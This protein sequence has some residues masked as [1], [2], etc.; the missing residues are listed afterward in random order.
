MFCRAALFLFFQFEHKL[1]CMFYREKAFYKS[2][3]TQVWPIY[4]MLEEIL[5]SCIWSVGGGGG[6]VRQSKTEKENPQGTEHH[7]DV[8][9]MPT[10][11][12]YL[13]RGPRFFAVV[14]YWLFSSLY[15]A[16]CKWR[17][18][19]NP[20][21]MSGFHLCIPRNET[22]QPSYFQNRIIMFCLPITT[23][24]YLWEIYIF[25]GLVCLFCS[26]QIYGPILGINKS[27]IDTWMYE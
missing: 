13:G 22:V 21:E 17:A 25:P 16:H 8:I 26:R 5:C 7:K 4:R 24:V 14:L 15:L 19:E 27:L 23:L 10:V 18:D 2:G 20:T 6:G 1:R 3:G 11:K 9:Y 12:E